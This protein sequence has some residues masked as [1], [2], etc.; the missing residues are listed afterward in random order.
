MFPSWTSL[1][2][3]IIVVFQIC[4]ILYI[5]LHICNLTASGSSDKA[6]KNWHYVVVLSLLWITWTLRIPKSWPSQLAK[7]M[8]T[9][10]HMQ[11]WT[12][13]MQ[14]WTAT[15]DSL[16]HHQVVL[17]QVM[18]MSH[19]KL[20]HSHTEGRQ[21]II[22]CMTTKSWCLSV[23]HV[24]GI[25]KKWILSSQYT[26]VILP[27]FPLECLYPGFVRRL[28]SIVVRN[29]RLDIKIPQHL[30]DSL[31]S[32]LVVFSLFAAGIGKETTYSSRALLRKNV[33]CLGPR[34]AW[35]IEC[36]SEADFVV[37]KIQCSRM[38]H[39][40]LPWAP[41]SHNDVTTC[42]LCLQEWEDNLLRN[43]EMTY[44]SLPEL[45]LHLKVSDWSSVSAC[46]KGDVLEWA[47]TLQIGIATRVKSHPTRFEC[48]TSSLSLP[49]GSESFPVKIWGLLSQL[50]PAQPK[51]IEHLRPVNV[52]HCLQS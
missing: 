26:K 12:S 23:E 36:S 11:L 48:W 44:L 28:W 41:H 43:F 16:R 34:L 39:R 25:V 13:C 29:L 15:H 32:S 1:R 42:A 33:E 4:L 8:V 40:Y 5:L 3:I 24:R 45:T 46:S 7:I 30:Q 49:V 6:P 35:V 21:K 38:M 18:C 31:L 27:R 37:G 19:S 10:S 17:H 9:P 50:W 47:Y 20:L 2:Y 14:T 52:T 51:T 22:S